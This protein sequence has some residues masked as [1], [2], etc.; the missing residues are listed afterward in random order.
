MQSVLIV[1]GRWQLPAMHESGRGQFASVVHVSYEP[2]SARSI[3]TQSRSAASSRQR[4]VAH[5]SENGQSESPAQPRAQRPSMH[6]E[7]L[8]R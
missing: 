3:V 2:G 7:A 4:P 5:A 6:A 1:H 8:P